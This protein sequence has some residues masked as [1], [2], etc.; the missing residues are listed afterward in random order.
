MAVQFLCSQFKLAEKRLGDLSS[1]GSGDDFDRDV[2]TTIINLWLGAVGK[3]F[4][5]KVHERNYPM[6]FILE[7][8]LNH[9]GEIKIQ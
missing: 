4:S 3:R 1:N 6:T 9:E 7:D 8:A 5:Y 2:T